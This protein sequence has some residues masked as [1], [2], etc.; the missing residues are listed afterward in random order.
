[1]IIDRAQFFRDRMASAPRV[2]VDEDPRHPGRV[3]FLPTRRRVSPMTID[4]LFDDTG[5]LAPRMVDV[6]VNFVPSHLLADAFADAA[7][8]INAMMQRALYDY[9]K[10]D[11]LLLAESTYGLGELT[12]RLHLDPEDRYVYMRR[13]VP[14]LKLIPG[15]LTLDDVVKTDTP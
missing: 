12:P 9:L 4:W 15:K 11:G 1:V 6:T 2:A 3:I 10:C 14:K 13:N 5:E 7:F 8:D